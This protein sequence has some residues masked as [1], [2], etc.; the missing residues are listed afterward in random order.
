MPVAIENDI[1]KT[2]QGARVDAVVH[3]PAEQCAGPE[4]GQQLRAALDDLRCGDAPRVPEQCERDQLTDQ[5]TKA[6]LSSA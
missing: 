1:T 4:R 5:K 6:L 2:P 3:E